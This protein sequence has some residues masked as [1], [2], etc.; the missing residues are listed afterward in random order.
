MLRTSEQRQNFSR[1]CIIKYNKLGHTQPHTTLCVSPGARAPAPAP[2]LL[3]R[4]WKFGIVTETSALG[5]ENEKLKILG[6]GEIKTKANISANFI[7]KQA[8]EKIEK[9]GG[10]LT[11]VKK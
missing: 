2:E 9:I 5:S 4:N 3:E 7:S 11:L 1:N 6:Q 10:K 8:K